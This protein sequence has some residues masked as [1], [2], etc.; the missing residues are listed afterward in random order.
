MKKSMI[1]KIGILVTLTLAVFVWGL[2]YLK[3]EKLLSPEDIYYIKY[4]KVDG[5]TKGADVVISG[6]KVG[7][8]RKISF[9][10]DHSGNLLVEI[11]IESRFELP[12]KT[13]AYLY[14]SDLMGTRA[15]QLKFGDK[16]TMHES[17]DTLTA[18]IEDALVEQVSAEMIPLKNKAEKLMLSFDSVLVAVQTVF[19]DQTRENLLNTFA[20]I[21]VTIAHL[22]RITYN[23]DHMV[24]SE[25]QKV[26]S[27]LTNLHAISSNLKNNNEKLANAINNV[28]DVSDSLAQADITTTI[29]NTN[30]ALANLN[31]ILEK[32]NQ[33]EGT[34]GML[35]HN[36]TIYNNLENITFNLN[37]LI[38][39]INENPKR[40]VNFSAID[41]GKD[42][43]VIEKDDPRAG[44]AKKIRKDKK[45]IREK[46]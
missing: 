30:K 32:I 6:Y 25:K 11:A 8:V 45:F 18:Q 19:N 43:Y 2:H 26:S 12:K 46:K 42:V 36:D 37:R 39:D 21:K 34:I 5:L 7:Q 41:M 20:G 10:P 35:V 28:S 38:R 44:K 9:T 3:G 4:D 14:S 13:T 1:I 40:Y 22:Q 29:N 24:N 15:I 17:G 23:L 33:G 16:N 27:I 31:Q